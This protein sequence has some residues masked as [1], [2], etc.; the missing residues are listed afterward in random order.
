[1][2]LIYAIVANGTVVL[3]EHSSNTGNFAN[4]ARRILEKIPPKDSRMS[5]VYDRHIFH[6]MVYDSITYLCMADEDFGRRS[7][8]FLSI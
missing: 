8:T 4:V 1:M 5:Y 3:A 2:P 6:I 7:L